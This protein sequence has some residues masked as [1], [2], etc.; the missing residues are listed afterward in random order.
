[1]ARSTTP[2]T[3]TPMIMPMDASSSPI[4]SASL[5]PCT[6]SVDVVLVGA[7]TDVT[8]YEP[9]NQ[10]EDMSAG[11]VEVRA[12]VIEDATEGLA[13]NVTSTTTVPND[14][15]GELPVEPP[16]EVPV[17]PVVGAPEDGGTDEGAGGWLPVV[18][19][20]VVEVVE[21]PELELADGGGGGGGDGGGGQP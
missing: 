6:R 19:L 11:E 17:D 18:A 4:V 10:M 21:L 14:A 20:P 1:M 15:A 3:P 5:P 8:V 16:F 2:P 13:T 12:V 9:P 7:L